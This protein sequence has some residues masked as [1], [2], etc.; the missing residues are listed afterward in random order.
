MAEEYISRKV[1]CNLSFSHG[2]NEDGILYIPYHEV[3]NYLQNISPANVRPAKEGEW[4][5]PPK[6]RDYSHLV[7]FYECPFC[8]Y[9]ED[10]FVN[11]CPNCGADMREVE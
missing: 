10:C 1:A 6:N 7:D 11:F 8:G 4:I 9:I 2:L 5:T 3:I